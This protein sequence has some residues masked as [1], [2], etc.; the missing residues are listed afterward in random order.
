MEIRKPRPN[1]KEIKTMTLTG[2][3]PKGEG[4]HPSKDPKIAYPLSWTHAM[5]QAQ[6]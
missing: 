2:R 3:I 5:V 6:D 1:T 4:H